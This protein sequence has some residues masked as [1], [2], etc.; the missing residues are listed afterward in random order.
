MSIELTVNGQHYEVQTAPNRT[1][2]EILRDDLRLTGTKEACSIG[3]CG[4][5][6]VLLDGRIVSSCLVLA[7]MADGAQVTTIEGLGSEDHL[8][9]VQQAFI[10]HGGFQCGICT[11]GQIVA[12]TALLDEIPSPTADQVKEWMTGNLCRCTG[13]Y[14]IIESILGAAD[15][16]SRATA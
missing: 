9:P 1:L 15:A 12:A 10:D 3:V 5:C 6:T 11:P 4:V 16:H 13:Y 14:T 7:Q 8:S 2:V